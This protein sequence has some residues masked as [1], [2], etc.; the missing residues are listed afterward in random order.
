MKSFN[1]ALVPSKEI[2]IYAAYNGLQIQEAVSVGESGGYAFD[3]KSK[4]LPGGRRDF[5]VKLALSAPPIFCQCSIPIP[6][7]NSK[8]SGFLTFSGG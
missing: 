2:G 1:K 5:F 4:F 8:N 3:P 7:E 6:P